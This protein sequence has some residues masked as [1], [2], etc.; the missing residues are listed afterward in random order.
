MKRDESKNNE[1]GIARRNVMAIL[2][3]L[4]LTSELLA[5]ES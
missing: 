2:M 1:R 5:H 4:G 3:F